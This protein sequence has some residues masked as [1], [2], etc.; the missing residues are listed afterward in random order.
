MSIPAQRIAEAVAATTA[1]AT[2]ADTAAASAAATAATAAAA[3]KSAA[4]AIDQA[5][6]RLFFPFTPKASRNGVKG[7]IF[8]IAISKN[9]CRRLQATSIYLTVLFT[10]AW[11]L[12]YLKSVF[13]Y[14]CPYIRGHLLILLNTM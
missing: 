3:A 9:R 4:T 8:E 14:C 7:N 6:S 11:L 1:A 5:D 2:A 13:R 12:I 10:Y